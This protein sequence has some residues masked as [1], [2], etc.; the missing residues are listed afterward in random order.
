MF[1]EQW[2][3]LSCA[4]S[5]VGSECTNTISMNNKQPLVKRWNSCKQ[6]ASTF[7]Y[8]L[9]LFCAL[10]KTLW[11]YKGVVCVSHPAQ[12]WRDCSCYSCLLNQ[13]WICCFSSGQESKGWGVSE[14]GFWPTTI[15]DSQLNTVLA[16]G[17]HFQSSQDCDQAVQLQPGEMW[18]E[19]LT[20][21]LN[22]K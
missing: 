12:Q 8:P 4:K 3:A 19:P 18:S 16:R 15:P 22:Q 17:F 1:S 11:L 21:V 20:A 13:H 14:Q 5:W 6:L 2:F 7:L 10:K 9:H